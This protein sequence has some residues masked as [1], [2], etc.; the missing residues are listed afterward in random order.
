MAP[1]S[2]SALSLSDRY[3]CPVCR[4][5]TLESLV[6]T[7]A[8][9]CNFCRHILAANLS[10]QQVQV[11]DISQ[12]VTWTWCNG[13]WALV[14]GGAQ[15]MSIAIILVAT[16]LILLPA[17]L[18]ALTGILFPPLKP[19]SPLSFSM[20]WALITLIAHL[21]LVL[22]LLG[23]YYQ[24]PFYLSVKMRLLYRRGWDGS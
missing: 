13:Q 17:G 10:E 4:E 23:E 14:R 1:Y 19:S 3:P 2:P 15:K 18:I 11:V 9:A 24:V 22:W 7:E 21:M 16:I 6:L 5:G 8:F 12:P 20:L